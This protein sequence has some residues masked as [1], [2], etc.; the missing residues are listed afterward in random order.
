MPQSN[1]HPAYLADHSP[2]TI[3]TGADNKTP[4]REAR[5]IAA[6]TQPWLLWGLGGKGHNSLTYLPLPRHLT[7]STNIRRRETPAGHWGYAWLH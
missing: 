2:C 6:G 7:T 4:E 1:Q 3:Y 5:K